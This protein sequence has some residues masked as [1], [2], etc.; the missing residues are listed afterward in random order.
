VTD[1]SPQTIRLVP[2]DDT[3]LKYLGAAAVLQWHNLPQDVQKSLLQ[4]SSAIGGLP[5]A[6]DLQRKIEALITRARG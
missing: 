2:G 1:M 4:Q 5:V 3:I 6:D